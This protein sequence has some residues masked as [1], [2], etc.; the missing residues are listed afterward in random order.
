MRKFLK[1]PPLLLKNFHYED[2]LA[3]LQMGMEERFL[4]GDT[5]VSEEEVVNSA[6]LIA[7]GK[8]SIW[9]DN[10]ELANLTEGNFIGETFLFSKNN[11]MAKVTSEGESILLKYERYD[12]LNFFRKRPEKLFNI[13]TKNIIEIQQKKVHNMN[14]QLISLKKR[15]LGDQ[16][17]Q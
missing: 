12:V 4:P 6:Y 2:V 8:V 1:E 5:I 14:V 13:F 3:F 10:I 7:E 9:K 17:W 11:R 16:N 15:L